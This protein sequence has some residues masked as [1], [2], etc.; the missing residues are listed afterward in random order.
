MTQ[1]LRWEGKQRQ[2]RSL[3]LVGLVHCFCEE[4]THVPRDLDLI[5]SPR[6]AMNCQNT[7]P[8]YLLFL[9]SGRLIDA[10]WS[11]VR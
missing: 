3:F 10:G 1:A 4:V 9:G 6:I 11:T 5:Q 8:L 7:L 2:L